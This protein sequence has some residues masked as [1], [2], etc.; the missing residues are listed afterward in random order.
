MADLAFPWERS[1]M[2]GT[3]MPDGLSPAEQH[4][5]QA[6]A[7]LYAR[8]R[9]KVISREEGHAEKGKIIFATEQKMR[10]DRAAADLA[11]WQA[12]LRKNIEAAQNRFLRARRRM[13]QYP[14]D[15]TYVAEALEAA[16]MMCAVVDGRVRKVPEIEEEEKCLTVNSAETP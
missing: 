10:A 4:A 13:E 9:L 5:W 15:P 8:F 12:E 6:L 1:A 3:G 7:H 11:V 2:E 16:D 14:D